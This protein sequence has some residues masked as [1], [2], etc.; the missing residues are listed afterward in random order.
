MFFENKHSTIKSFCEVTCQNEDKGFPLH[1][2]SAYECYAI[3]KGRA[4]AKIDGK[5]YVLS[6]GEAVLV[7]PYQSHE[8]ETDADTS[9]W[10]CIF[11]TDLVESYNRHN[12][13]VPTDNKFS[14]SPDVPS[15]PKGLLMKKSLCYNICGVFD[16]GRK[17]VKTDGAQINLISNLLLFISENYRS[18]CTL[19]L[20]T[21]NIG[22]DYNYVSKLFKKTVKMSFNTYVNKLRINEAC[23]LLASTNL[24]VQEVAETCGYSCTRT[25]HREFLKSTGKTP[26][27][28]R[29]TAV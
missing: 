29:K 27:E 4:I 5:E 6:P 23:R 18:E 8:Y 3:T 28:Y 10:F 26:T 7:F 19:Q 9:T 22:Y 14:F 2:H 1:I 12:G 16:E 11:S 17:Y 13:Y 24:S 25:F 20:A 21:K 15:T